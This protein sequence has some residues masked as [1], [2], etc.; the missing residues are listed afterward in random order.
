MTAR[1]SISAE[2]GFYVVRCA[3]VAA[4][5]YRLAV[6]VGLQHPVWAPMSALIVSQGTVTATLQSIWGR[7]L[8]TLTG[9]AAALLVSWLGGFVG[10]GVMLQV[11]MAVALCATIAVEQP[12]LR[13]CLWTCPIILTSGVAGQATALVAT[14]RVAEVVLGAAVGGLLA[15]VS[16]LLQARLSRV[17][18]L[19][20]P[21][22]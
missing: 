4:L 16:E 1:P 18:P 19:L 5:A 20:Q 12:Q 17:R 13:V 21:E 22:P 11:G 14:S 3:T 10:L 9:V 7:C 2:R 6:L 8:G 15:A